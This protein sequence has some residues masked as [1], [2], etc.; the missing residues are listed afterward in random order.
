MRTTRTGLTG[1]AAVLAILLAAGGCASSG[2]TG[3]ASS[4]GN[5]ITGEAL[6]ATHQNNL[7][8]ALQSLRPQWLRSR[9]S[10][11][12]TSSTEVALFVNEAPY[13]TVSD[14]SSIPIDAVRDVRFMSASEAGSRYGTS[15]GAGG[16]LLVRLKS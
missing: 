3:S 4:S 7:Y 16:L 14:L 13:G 15:A 5:V 10:A 6:M 2:S 12:L 9:A 1:G 8:Q 11:S